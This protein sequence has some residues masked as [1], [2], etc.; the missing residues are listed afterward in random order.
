MGSVTG[1]VDTSG[2]CATAAGA[3]IS[4][5][6]ALTAITLNRHFITILLLSF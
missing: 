1:K 4:S 3:A 5:A 2:V 6:K